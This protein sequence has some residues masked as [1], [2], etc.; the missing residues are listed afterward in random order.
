MKID[1]AGAIFDLD[2]TLVDSLFL[3]DKLWDE[4][5][6]RF[7]SDGRFR[8]SAADD[9]AVRTM[10]LKEV[11]AHIHVRYGIGAD[12]EELLD[13]ANEMI[14]RFYDEEVTLKEGAFEFLRHAKEQG[15]R[16][17]VASATA[18]PLVEAAVRHCGLEDFFVFVLSC[19]EIGKGKNEPDIFL[20]A[21]ERLGT[22]KEKTWVFED[23][24]LALKT[25]KSIGLHT[26][27]I[28]DTYNYGQEEL[29]ASADHYIGKGSSLKDLI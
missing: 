18:R 17:C 16:M 1:I 15:V 11:A 26:V 6:A 2:G 13:C 24:P 7:C 19:A 25:A 22:P 3:W 4:Y 20:R 8:P 5:G 23:S 12:A 9:R 21:T 28:Y 10:T 14:S 29:Q 27:G